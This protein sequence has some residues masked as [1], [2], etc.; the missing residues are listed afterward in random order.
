[1]RNIFVF[2]Y[3]RG[4]HCPTAVALEVRWPL[5]PL[6][7]P[8]SPTGVLLP[9]AEAPLPLTLLFF[10]PLLP[11][12]TLVPLVLVLSYSSSSTLITFRV[13]SLWTEASL[14]SGTTH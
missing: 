3:V 1:M 10:L 11:F 13:S 12:T 8:D 6:P 4:L 5:T 9:E 7:L 14:S 2:V